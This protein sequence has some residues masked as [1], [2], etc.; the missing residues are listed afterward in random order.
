MLSV[1]LVEESEDEDEASGEEGLW[2]G[3][4]A[5]VRIAG[6]GRGGGFDFSWIEGRERRR[7]DI[8]MVF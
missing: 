8:S 7:S 5:G 3:W 4:V 2:V 1:V 6:P